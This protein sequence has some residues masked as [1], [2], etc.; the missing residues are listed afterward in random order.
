[1]YINLKLFFI[2][3]LTTIEDYPFIFLQKAKLSFSF[4]SNLDNFYLK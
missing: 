2:L 3:N 4:R 1:M